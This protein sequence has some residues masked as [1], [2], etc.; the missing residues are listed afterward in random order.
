MTRSIRSTSSR[1]TCARSS[2]AS[3]T[4]A[5]AAGCASSSAPRSRRCSSY[6]D[7][8][9]DQDAAQAHEGRARPGR[10]R[11]LPV[12]A[13]LRQLPVHPR[14]T[15]VGPRLP[16]ADDARRRKCCTRHASVAVKERAPT[17]RSPTPICSARSMRDAA[18]LTNA[19]MARRVDRRA[20]RWR[21]SSA[22]PRERVL[23]PYAKQRFSTWFKRKR[24]A[25][26]APTRQPAGHG[27]VV[28]DVL[29]RIPGRRRSATTWSRCSS[30]TA[31]SVRCP[32]RCSAAARRGSHRATSTVSA[33]KPRKNVAGAGRRDAAARPATS[34][35]P[36][37]RAATS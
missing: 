3:T 6:I 4:C 30:A 24:A 16:A 25:I 19:V 35:F 32:R 1:P 8:H 9:D 26:A 36:N 18:P 20:R 5:T 2:R 33:S 31:S 15:R 17:R 7:R 27:R 28:P 37:R 14:P 29:R 21:R 12:Q 22:S 11:V 34:S 23:P 13:L 10:R